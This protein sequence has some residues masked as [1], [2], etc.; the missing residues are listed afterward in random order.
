MFPAVYEP[1]EANLL[2]KHI[3]FGNVEDGSYSNPYA[4]L[5]KGYRQYSTSKILAQLELKQ[6]FDFI[7]KGL[8]ARIMF[9]TDR[10]AHFEVKREYTPYY[11]ALSDYDRHTD[12]Y[13]L[14]H[15]NPGSSE[16]L[17]YTEMVKMSFPPFISRVMCPITVRLKK[18]MP[19]ED[20]WFI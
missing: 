11:Y 5:V 7:T 9:N 14:K 1:D 2:A 4:D 10:R 8:E 6:N 13:T 18:S 16:A 17:N 3:L 19:S 12:T 15:V 20:S